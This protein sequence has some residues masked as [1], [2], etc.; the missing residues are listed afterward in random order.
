MNQNNEVSPNTEDLAEGARTRASFYS[1]LNVHFVTLPDIGFVEWIRSQEFISALENLAT[2]QA[3]PTDLTEGASLMLT[4]L[5]S[6]ADAEAA[7]LSEELGVERTRL[8]RG[9]SPQYSPTPPC[10]GAWIIGQTDITKIL[11]KL[12]EIYRRSGM[13][14]ST[15]ARERLDYIGVELDYMRLLALREAECWQSGDEDTARELLREQESFL[16]EHLGQWAP[17][18]I[19]KALSKA[20]NDF[21]RGHLIMLRGFL[22][23]EKEYIL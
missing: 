17:F 5:R 10:E 2:D 19:E 3:F 7:C 21:Y 16:R 8:Y 12:S 11:Q 20:E 13:V 22:S 14:L 18:F 9:I 15:D 1:L 4:Y 23:N 6:K